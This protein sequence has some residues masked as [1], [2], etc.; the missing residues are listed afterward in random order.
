MRTVRIKNSKCPWFTSEVLEAIN[1]RRKLYCKWKDRPSTRNWEDYCQA[2][3]HVNYV[4]RQAK[5]NYY[6]SKFSTSLTSKKLWSNLREIGIGRKNNVECL[7][8]PN[9]LNDTFVFRESI[10]P[11][12]SPKNELCRAFDQD[13]E[14]VTESDVLE[15]VN[16]IKSNAIGE[17]GIPLC[18]IKLILPYIVGPLTHIINHSIVSSTFPDSWKTAQ[19]LPIAKKSN[20]VL[21]ADYRPVSILPTLSKVFEKIL[22][23]Q[24]I[25]HLDRKC[26]LSP[27]QSG[28]RP[29]HSC[30]TAMVKILDDIRQQFDRGYLTILCLL[31]FSKAFDR[32]N[33]NIL[34]TKLRCYFGFSIRAVQLIASYL[35]NR[36]QRVLVGEHLSEAKYLKEGV[37]Q[38]SIL[39]PVLFCIFINDLA[40]HCKSSSFHLYADDVQVYLSRPIGLI[41]DLFC[42]VN[43]D[44]LAI[45]KWSVENGLTL[46]PSKSQA[47]MISQKAYE[48]EDLPPIF[49]SSTRIQ[50]V[51]NVT[52]LGYKINCTLSCRNQ[53]NYTIGRIYGCLRKLWI[54]ARFIPV[55]TK[56]KLMKTLLVPIISYAEVVYC[57]LDSVSMHKLQVAFNNMVRYVYGLRRYD[58]VSLYQNSILG[59]TLAQFLDARNCI[60]LHKIIYSRLPTYLFTK[61][62]FAQS[63]RTFNLIIQPFNYLNSTRLF[64]TY[65]IRLW[66]SLPEHIKRTWRASSFKK[67]ILNHFSQQQ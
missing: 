23:K 35:R 34:C 67:A 3:N 42:R 58:H 36:S 60:F 5:F 38:G 54:C 18:F 29:N 65:T 20:P 43:E 41:E 4:T 56:L 17:D 66:N 30:A 55:D 13:F 22:T 59:C 27:F 19:I 8:D 64:F 9:V 24:I 7:L 28:F 40:H 61:L 25:G 49:L 10:N 63:A 31:D 21:P 2:R 62:Q 44:L 16:G 26:L 51:D 6:S 12:F 46:N 47:I 37:P 11:Q 50:F 52:S 53:I 33:H 48:T 1:K 14:T 15:S 32:V 45:Y 57:K 39:G